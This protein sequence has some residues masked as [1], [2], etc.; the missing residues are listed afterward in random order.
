MNNLLQLIKEALKKAE[1]AGKGK[2]TVR[3]EGSGKYRVIVKSDNYKD[4]E[5]LMEKAATSATNF[6]EDNKGQ[7]SFARLEE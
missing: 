5:K 2:I 7:A 3:Y 6:I 4:A 1:N